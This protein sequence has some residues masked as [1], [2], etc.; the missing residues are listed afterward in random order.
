MSGNRPIVVGPH[1]TREERIGLVEP[2][3]YW[4]DFE[5]GY[6]DF[7]AA[8]ENTAGYYVRRFPSN[9]PPSCQAGQVAATQILAPLRYP[10]PVGRTE[11]MLEITRIE[12]LYK[13]NGASD[14][15]DF[16]VRRRDRSTGVSF[17]VGA[18]DEAT[19]FTTTGLFTKYSETLSTP[20]PLDYANYSYG[21]GAT[22]SPNSSV[23]HVDLGLI[24]LKIRAY[25]LA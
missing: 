24:R 13:R 17:A 3:E 14:A 5:P 15:L 8:E 21:L 9:T 20:I 1:P 16:V 12:L 10:W 2:A 6:G 19:H 7:A 11:L 4:L 25:A 23:A 22:L 18:W